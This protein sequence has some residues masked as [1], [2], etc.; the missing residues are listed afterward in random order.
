[1]MEDDDEFNDIIDWDGGELKGFCRR[2][3]DT[4]LIRK[5]QAQ[6]KN[7]HQRHP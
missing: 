1:M 7:T 3:K 2:H 5:K 6:V 4:A